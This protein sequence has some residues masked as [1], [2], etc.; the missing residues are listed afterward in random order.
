MAIN[1]SYCK[2]ENTLAALNEC[3][4]DWDECS[5]ER[6]VKAKQR[7][8]ELMVDLLNEEGYE[9]EE[10]DTDDNTDDQFVFVGGD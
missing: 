1:M 5:N 6:E 7:L 4:Y 8:I 3:A 2:F 9:I 10:P